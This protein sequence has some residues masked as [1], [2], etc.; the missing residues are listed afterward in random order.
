MAL[1][2]RYRSIL[3]LP[4]PEPVSRPRM[5]RADR[6]AQ[7][8][9]FAA[10]NGYEEVLKESARQTEARA[11][12]DEETAQRLNAAFYRLRQCP[13]DEVR[14]TYFL[15]DARKA[16]GRYASVTGRVHRVDEVERRLIFASGEEIP[17]DD[18]VS[19]EFPGDTSPNG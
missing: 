11:E 16:G 4:H 10:L 12:L 8:A 17:L 15:P 5:S 13:Q 18:V 14:A 1:D 2:E 9:S 19:L 3:H 6:A 7:F